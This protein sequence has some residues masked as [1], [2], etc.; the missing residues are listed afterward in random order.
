[1]VTDKTLRLAQRIN[2]WLPGVGLILAHRLWLGLAVGVLFTLLANLVIW[3]AA[4]VPDSVPRF[5]LFLTGGLLA[6]TYA[7]AQYLLSR[8]V[9]HRRAAAHRAERTRILNQ[10]TEFL[11][12]GDIDRAGACVEALLPHAEDDLMVAVRV[13]QTLTAARD[14][15]RGIEAWLRVR[16]LDIQAVYRRDA[17]EGERILRELLLARDSGRANTHGAP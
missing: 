3:G 2:W 15:P 14:A 7:G 16:R 4:I 10:A 12:R 9:R 5:F 6:G 13:A 11:A 17:E 1:M 8:D